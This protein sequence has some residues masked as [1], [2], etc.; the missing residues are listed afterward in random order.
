MS[1][2][3][4]RQSDSDSSSSFSEPGVQYFGLFTFFGYVKYFLLFKKIQ[5]SRTRIGD[6]Y[7]VKTTQVSNC[8]WIVNLC[9]PD[10]VV[11][12]LNIHIFTFD[13]SG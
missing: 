9:F 8:M 13:L 5:E 6:D 4:H 2:D 1:S 12:I 11:K 10:C 7:Q 3:N